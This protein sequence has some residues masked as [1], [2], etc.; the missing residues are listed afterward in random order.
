M[1]QEKIIFGEKIWTPNIKVVYTKRKKKI[2][3]ETFFQK[4]SKLFSF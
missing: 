2:E 4:I 3:K 1:L